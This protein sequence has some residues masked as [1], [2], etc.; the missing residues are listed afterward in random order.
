MTRC[1]S[2]GAQ[3]AWAKSRAGKNI[4]LDVE[5]RAD[6]NLVLVN[7]V[8][9]APEAAPLEVQGGPRYASHFA[10]CPHAPAH[11]RGT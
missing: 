11:R 8:A 1:K 10:T 6:G 3:I 4:P 7:G 9:M 2:C 5:P